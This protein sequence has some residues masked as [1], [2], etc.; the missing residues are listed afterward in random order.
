MDSSSEVEQAQ[1]KSVWS[2]RDSKSSTLLAFQGLA[3]GQLW[4]HGKW[5][6]KVLP[7]I[8]YVLCSFKNKHLLVL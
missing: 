2:P 7:Y 5:A 3:L 1:L 8:F 6:G 4:F